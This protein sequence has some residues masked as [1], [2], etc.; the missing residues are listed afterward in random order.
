MKLGAVLHKYRLLTEKTLRELGKEISGLAAM[1]EQSLQD[2]HDILRS[3][4]FQSPPP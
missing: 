2:S 1:A 4:G 3:L